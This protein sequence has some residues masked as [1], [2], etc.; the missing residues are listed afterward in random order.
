MLEYLA[1][2]L[3]SLIAPRIPPRI[4]YNLFGWVGVISYWLLPRRRANVRRNLSIV[5]GSRAPKLNNLVREVFREGARY[6][7]DNFRIPALSDQE[8]ERVVN[9]EG[10]DNLL[11]A[12]SAGKGVVLVTAHL[13]SP[14]LVAQILAA[15]R[16][17]VVTVA[18]AIEPPQLL[19]LMIREDVGRAAPMSRSQQTW[20]G[21]L[22]AVVEGTKVASKRADH[23]ESSGASHGAGA[24]AGTGPT[25]G[26]GYRQR[27]TVALA[28]G[29]VRKAEELLAFNAQS[30]TGGPSDPKVL[31][32]FF[33]HRIAVRH[34]DL[35]GHGKGTVLSRGRSTLV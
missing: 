10:W 29:E 18:E 34:R 12:L 14:V 35:P 16:C 31:P 1:F 24:R 3:L 17:K 5:L 21:N 23:F 28:I 9:L 15:R 8:L 25:D 30:H 26:Q 13:G 20:R 33:D 11:K 32:N 6:Y 19:D 7:Y 27:A 2:S 22:R 4:A